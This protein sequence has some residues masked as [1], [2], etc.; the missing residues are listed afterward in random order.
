VI[1]SVLVTGGAGFIGSHVVDHFLAHGARVT[2]IDNFVTGKRSNVSAE[3]ELLEQDIRAPETAALIRGRQFDAICHLAAQIDVRKSVDDPVYDGSV[4]V[5]GTVNLLEAARQ[6]ASK[7]RIVFSSTGGALYGDFVT[8]PS[9]EV[10]PK[11][12][13]SAYGVGKLAAEYYM[14]YFARVHGLETVALRFGNVYGP[15]QDP[16]GEAG[17]VAIFC[18]R[19]LTGRPLTIFGDGTQ[20][21]DYVYVGD[22]ARA[23][24][25]AATKPLPPMRQLDSRAF[26]LG[27]GVGTSVLDLAAALKRAARSDA[28]VE[29]APRRAGELQ[30]S[31]LDVRKAAGELGWRPTMSIENGVAETFSW[32]AARHAAQPV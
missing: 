2:V 19:I 8:P 16:H 30:E 1:R 11:D 17:V 24:V 12:P 14:A 22:I 18:N 3:A 6:S 31:V 20:T 15:R 32:F 27:T 26:N 5:L 29:H 25:M 23:I 4:N 7:P 13:D 9:D 10:T 21:R 28:I